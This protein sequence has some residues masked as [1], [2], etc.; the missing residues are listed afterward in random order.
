MDPKVKG[1][2]SRVEER[3]VDGAETFLDWVSNG[4]VHGFV[5]VCQTRHGN[6]RV[7][8]RGAFE[9]NLLAGIGACKHGADILNDV[10]K[11]GLFAK[12]GPR[13]PNDDEVDV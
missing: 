7:M 3:A 12:F 10:L 4:D 5:V 2:Q 11:N 13:D 8:S 9:R 6:V 1:L